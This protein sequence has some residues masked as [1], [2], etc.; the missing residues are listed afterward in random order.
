[1][2]IINA[3]ILTMDEVDFENGYI[4]I[5]DGIIADVGPMEQM[6]SVA[7]EMYDAK[8]GYAV[9][10]FIDAHSHIGLFGAGEGYESNDANEP[11]QPIAPQL[12]A[13][14]GVNI[15]DSYFK[16]AL[17]AGITTVAVSPGSANVI[18]GQVVVMKTY[19]NT[20]DEA[21]IKQPAAVKVSFGEN[22]KKG[23]NNAPATRMAVAALLRQAFYDAMAYRDNRHSMDLKQD[24]LCRVLDGEIPLHAHVH[25]AD[26]IAT[27]IRIAKEFH[28][29]LKLIHAT[30]GYL[31]PNLLL[32]NAVDVMAGPLLCDRGKP[33]MRNLSINNVIKLFECGID[34]AI[35]TD[36]PELPASYLL[37]SAQL[38]VKNGADPKQ[39]LRAITIDAAR[40]LDIDNRVG[41]ITQGNDGDILVF[42]K[43]PMN[44]QAKLVDIFIKS[45][46]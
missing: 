38:A 43:N 20:V 40:I 4:L 8:G 16:E 46:K 36:H 37:L 9:P 29:K 2:L 21:V 17:H 3:N 32:E 35:I 11:T 22:P 6:P 39:A 30:E 5:E 28:I 26:D 15:H 34:M 45:K 13:L 31:V 1:M 27:A 10:G 12:R 24:I 25:R 18:G 33:E 41:K 19:G 7:G 44:F 23:P 14:D 42:D